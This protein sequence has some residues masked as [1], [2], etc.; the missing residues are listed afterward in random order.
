MLEKWYRKMEPSSPSGQLLAEPQDAAA[1]LAQVRL[2]ACGRW[3]LGLAAASPRRAVS[4]PPSAAPPTP[5]LGAHLTAG[6]QAG[7]PG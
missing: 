4:L 3:G 6:Q 1:E 2:Q 7:S 5:S